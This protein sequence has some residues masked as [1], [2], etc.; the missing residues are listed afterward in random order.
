MISKLFIHE[1]IYKRYMNFFK[2]YINFEVYPIK[3]L[4]S[5]D[6]SD[7][8]IDNYDLCIGE[9]YYKKQF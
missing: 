9:L 6:I 3:K 7:N 2:E 1:S 5:G 4:K 8:L